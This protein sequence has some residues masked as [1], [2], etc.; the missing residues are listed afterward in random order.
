MLPKTVDINTAT[1]RIIVTNRIPSQK[2]VKLDGLCCSAT[3]K[4]WVRKS[5]T[6]DELISTFW[7][8]VLHALDFEYGCPNLNHE[9]IYQLETPLAWFF[10]DN[11]QLYKLWMIESE[12]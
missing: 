5:L 1:Y 9:A 10:Q 3:K 11:P 4:I 8:E 12:G 2:G 6:P 7:H